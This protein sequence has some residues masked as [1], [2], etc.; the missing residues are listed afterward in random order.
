[1]DNSSSSS[2]FWDQQYISVR[3]TEY[4][5]SGSVLDKNVSTVFFGTLA[6]GTDSPVKIIGMYV[7]GAKEIANIKLGVTETNFRSDL[8]SILMYSVG[9]DIG[10]LPDPSTPFPGINQSGRGDDPNNIVV[11][12]IGTSFQSKYIA[13]K[14]RS[15]EG[16]VFSSQ[17]T[18]EWFFDFS[19]PPFQIIES[20]SSVSSLSSQ[21]VEISSSSHS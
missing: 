8:S 10:S 6:P 5:K 15:P 13:L 17:I 7:T 16:T 21:S 3:M 12:Q 4:G 18:F 2:S 14:I 19:L 20:S 11:G 9:D 1:M